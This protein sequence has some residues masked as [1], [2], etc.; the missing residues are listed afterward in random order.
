MA[1]SNYSLQV[2]YDVIFYFVISELTKILIESYREGLQSAPH[3][4][5]M[6]RGLVQCYIALQR[7]REAL[8]IAGNSLHHIGHT[9]RTFTVNIHANK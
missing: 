7:S 5:E 2:C 4:F 3:R 9:P 6:Y 1:R 8:T